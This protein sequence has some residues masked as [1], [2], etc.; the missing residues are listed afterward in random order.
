MAFE[1]PNDLG[2]RSMKVRLLSN[3]IEPDSNGMGVDQ[4]FEQLGSRFQVDVTYPPMT[5]DR[6]RR[7]VAALL[8]AAR[9]ETIFK[10]RQP[11]QPAAQR[12]ALGVRPWSSAS[13]ANATVVGL[14]GGAATLH[15]G[16]LFSVVDA[17]GRP[18]LHAVVQDQMLPS[19]AIIAP[20]LRLPTS[21]LPGGADFVNPRVQGFG[22]K[23]VEW[24]VDVAHHYG[25]TFS[26]KERK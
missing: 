16:Q 2:P 20:A 5:Y 19:A 24:D 26:I 3:A 9:E 18:R 21:D 14:G 15:A 8:R 13:S 1:F 7:L 6:A 12:A 25:L 22:P 17:T 11:G 4:R 10:V 23:N